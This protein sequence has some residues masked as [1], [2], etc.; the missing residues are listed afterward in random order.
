MERIFTDPYDYNNSSC[1][2][3]AV[4]IELHLEANQPFLTNSG[5]AFLKTIIICRW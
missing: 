3:H 4:A 1:C 2:N 5:W